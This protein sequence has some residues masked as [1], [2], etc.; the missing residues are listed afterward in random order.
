VSDPAGE[1]RIS[2]V[3]WLSD[4]VRVILAPNPSPMTLEG[5]NTYLVGDADGLIVIDPGPN[6]DRHIASIQAAVA[7]ADVVSILLTHHHIDHDEAAARTADLLGTGIA[8]S[9]AAGRDG[10][11]QIAD[12]E[13]FGGAGVFLEAVATPGHSSDHLCFLFD[14]EHALFTGDHILGRGTTVVAFPDGDMGAYMASL[15]R[16]KD[17][18][19]ERFYPGHGPVIDEPTPV[20]TEYIEHRRMR[21]RQVLDGLEAGPAS[22]EELVARIYVDVDPILHPVAAMSVRAHLAELARR[23]VTVQDGDRW[24]LS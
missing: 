8:S 17:L 15:E 5:T 9:V 20:V 12:G 4:R 7:D 14:E 6:D 1:V 24:R 23:G 21:E 16:V 19:A 22:P 3:R 10:E 2:A 13:R 18:G 11:T